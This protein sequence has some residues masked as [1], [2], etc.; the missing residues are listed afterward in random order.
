VVPI[1]DRDVFRLMNFFPNILDLK[2]FKEGEDAVGLM[3]IIMNC[4]IVSILIAKSNEYTNQYLSG[5]KYP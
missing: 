1:D 5:T 3:E 2:S 4:R